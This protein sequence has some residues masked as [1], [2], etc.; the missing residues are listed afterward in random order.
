MSAM[1]RRSDRE[2]GQ[3]LVLTTLLVLVLLLFAG[4]AVDAGY[5]FVQMRRAQN[6]ADFAATAATQSIMSVCSARASVSNTQVSA[7]IEALVSANAPAAAGAWQAYYLDAQGRQMTGAT[8]PAAAGQVPVGACGVKV[9]ARPS[10]RPFFAQLIGLKTLSTWATAA[11][12]VGDNPAATAVGHWTGIVALAPSGG[13]TILGGGSGQ[14]VVNGNIMDNSVGK[15]GTDGYADTV[16]NF[17]NSST[18]INGRMDAVALNPLDS[19]FYPAGLT[20]ATCAAHTSG[21]ITYTGGIHGGLAPVKDPLAYVPTPTAQDAACPPSDHPVINPMPVSGAYYP[22]VYTSPVVI[23]GN[24]TLADCGGSPGVYIFE[25]GVAI[26]PGLG[27]TVTGTDV[28]LYSTFGGPV[29]T[30]GCATSSGGD[31]G[32]APHG[33]GSSCPGGPGGGAQSIYIGGAGVVDLQGPAAGPYAHMVLYQERTV[34]ANIGLDTQSSDSASI[35]VKGAIYDSGLGGGTGGKLVSG[36]GKSCTTTSVGD[37]SVDG[38]VVV[39]SFDTQ[40]TASVVI[41]YDPTQV[42]GVGAVLAY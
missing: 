13:H 32:P 25:A 19:C 18:I 1:M 12:H 20:F 38:I 3:I 5:G 34:P 14:F 40:G 21:S 36:Q 9:V 27:E 4:V 11:A 23:A 2:S 42:P 33:P 31:T 15:A 7:V 26:C 17:E 22:G 39:S 28:M 6:A 10:W 41:T 24:A 16:D 35:S 37:I 8:L 30:S 29:S